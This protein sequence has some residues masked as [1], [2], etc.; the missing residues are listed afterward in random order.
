MYECC[1]NASMKANGF[2]SRSYS[3]PMANALLVDGRP[4]NKL[5]PW[6]LIKT[7]PPSSGQIC[8]FGK[9]FGALIPS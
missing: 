8:K 2:P 5:T 3:Y 4:L 1:K 6:V 9:S 7:M